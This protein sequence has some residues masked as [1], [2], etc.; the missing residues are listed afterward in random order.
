M[1]NFL[2]PAYAQ[3]HETTRTR[4]LIAQEINSCFFVIVSVIDYI[5]KTKQTPNT[6]IVLYL[7]NKAQKFS[8][9]DILTLLQS[10]CHQT[11]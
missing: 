2:R 8:T 3:G 9:D 7:G 11:N 6:I 4:E 10:H 5:C 1:Q